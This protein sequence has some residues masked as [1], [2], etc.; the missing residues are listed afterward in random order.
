M[1]I[2]SYYIYPGSV[3]RRAKKLHAVKQYKNLDRFL[4]TQNATHYQTIE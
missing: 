3:S 2:K 4:S 1:G